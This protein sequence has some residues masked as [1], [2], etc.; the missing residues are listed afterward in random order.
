MDYAKIHR[1]SCDVIKK[2]FRNN[3]NVFLDDK[4]SLYEISCESLKEWIDSPEMQSRLYVYI[5]QHGEE[6]AIEEIVRQ[7]KLIINQGLKVNQ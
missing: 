3:K 1:I 2:H 5:A 7:G 4:K 6:K